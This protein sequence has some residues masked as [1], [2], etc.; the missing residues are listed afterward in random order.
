MECFGAFYN[1]SQQPSP[2]MYFSWKYT[3]LFVPRSVTQA[4][5]EKKKSWMYLFYK[6]TKGSEFCLK[7]VSDVCSRQSSPSEDRESVCV[8]AQV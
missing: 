4:L 1:Y 7:V 6:T 3:K 5:H 2:Q 8:C